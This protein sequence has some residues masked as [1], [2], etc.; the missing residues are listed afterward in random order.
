MAD[1]ILEPLRSC[2]AEA[3]A[4]EMAAEL[5]RRDFECFGACSRRV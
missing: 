2:P 3:S 1:M 5:N 4:I